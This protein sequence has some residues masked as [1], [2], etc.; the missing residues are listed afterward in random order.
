MLMKNHAMCK[1]IRL[2]YAW[3]Q[4][5]R[6][7][8][9]YSN[10]FF[11][12]VLHAMGLAPIQFNP[13]VFRYLATLFVLFSKLRLGEPTIAKLASIYALKSQPSPGCANKN[14]GV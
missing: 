12:K 11:R 13:N 10:L 1:E 5:I 3:M 2:L 6:G 4:S 7:L 8:G 9:F 14:Y